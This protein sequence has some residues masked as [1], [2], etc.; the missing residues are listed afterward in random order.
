MTDEKRDSLVHSKAWHTIAI[1]AGDRNKQV[2]NTYHVKNDIHY[3]DDGNFIKYDPDRM[4]GSFNNGKD[5]A[6]LQFRTFDRITVNPS[7]FQ[8]Q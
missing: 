1:E 2:I 5:I 6:T 8:K 4:Y 3:D 7:F